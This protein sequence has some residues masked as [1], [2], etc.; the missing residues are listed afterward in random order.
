MKEL[1]EEI[2]SDINGEDLVSNILVFR[3]LL[4]HVYAES[5][6]NYLRI[7]STEIVKL[8]E[9]FIYSHD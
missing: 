1:F 6:E 3:T 5:S 4:S 7:D 2:S 8:V 9:V